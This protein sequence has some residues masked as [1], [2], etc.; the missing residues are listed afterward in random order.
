MPV[1]PGLLAL[2]VDGGAVGCRV[3]GTVVVGR[4]V[5][6]FNDGLFV[7]INEGRDVGLFVG[8]FVGRDVG[9]FVGVYVGRNVGLF[10]GVFVGRNVGLFVGLFVVGLPVGTSVAA[11]R[12]CKSLI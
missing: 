3:V 4:R 11:G 7:G 10:V 9:L 5:D 2:G 12:P 6:G 8:V 1:A